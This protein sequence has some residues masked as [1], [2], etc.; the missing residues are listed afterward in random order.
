MTSNVLLT[1]PHPLFCAYSQFLKLGF[2]E[3]FPSVDDCPGIKHFVLSM[4]GNINSA[5]EDYILTKNF[6]FSKSRKSEGTFN[7]FRNE[8]ETF[9]LWCW[10]KKEKSII[11]L[12][13]SDIEEYIEFVHQPDVEWIGYNNQRRFNQTSG[14]AKLNEEWRPFVIKKA[15]GSKA[16]PRREDYRASNDRLL[17]TFSVLS[18]LFDYLT[19]EEYVFGNPISGI[20]RDSPFLIKNETVVTVKRLSNLQWE[21]LLNTAETSANENSKFERHLF[22]ISTM[23]TLYLRV[24]ELSDRKHWQPVM[25]HYTRDNEGNWWLEVH[26]KGKKTRSV[27]VPDSY[28]KYLARYRQYRDLSPLP[29]RNEKTPLIHKLIGSGG[30]A[31]RSIALLVQEMF[32]ITALAMIKDGFIEE[33]QSLKEH[34]SHSL[35]HLGA[36][37]SA[38]TRPLKHLSEELGHKSTS[39]T[40]QIYYKTDDVERA[41][42]GKNRE[43]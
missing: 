12:R 26:G 6:L 19:T 22:V 37:E 28:L 17:G 39:T 4:A 34:S 20:R 11:D 3:D 5:K 2:K 16:Q 27:T 33:A 41:A 29:T 38:K 25:G 10:I 36:S 42:S 1:K 31:V 23:K 43:V 14:E 32:E 21:Y 8:V 7:Q 9:L 13:R 18:S 24:S 15:K 30:L 40:D 35:R